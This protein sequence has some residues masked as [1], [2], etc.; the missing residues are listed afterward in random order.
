MKM[1]DTTQGIERIA[2]NDGG[3][4]PHI[5]L[6]PALVKIQ[7]RTI[8]N[9]LAGLDPAHKDQFKTNLD[10]FLSDIDQLDV[11]I[12]TTMANTRSKKFIVFHP[13]WVNY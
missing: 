13:A 2:A 4:D 1:V 11:Q 9:A 12:R 7:S 6:S 3:F 5:W 10:A 8:Y